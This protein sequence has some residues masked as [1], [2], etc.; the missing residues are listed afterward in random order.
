MDLGVSRTPR[1][2]VS[3]AQDL[4]QRWMTWSWSRCA[5]IPVLAMCRPH[6]SASRS[7]QESKSAIG[8][9]P[10]AVRASLM[11]TI[12]AVSNSSS[13]SVWDMAS[14]AAWSRVGTGQVAACAVEGR[15][16]RAAAVMS[17]DDVTAAR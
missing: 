9:L 7:V 16:R 10:L 17:S 11:V 13:V 14:G 3:P 8:R 2:R 15:A 1:T 6:R 12:R 5:K 4:S